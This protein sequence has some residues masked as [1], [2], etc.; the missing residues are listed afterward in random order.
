MS[1]AVQVLRDRGDDDGF[2][3]AGWLHD[4]VEDMSVWLTEIRQRFG[5]GVAAM[6]DACTGLRPARHNRD[7]RIDTGLRACPA[8]AAAVKLAD[9][10]AT[11]RRTR[12]A[13]STG[14]G[15]CAKPLHFPR[16]FACAAPLSFAAATMHGVAPAFTIWA[17]A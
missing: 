5:D 15:I 4:M 1:A 9:R 13:V 6:V 12:R 10:I 11:S 17:I 7:T 2:Q 16:S 14:H 8:A 3:E